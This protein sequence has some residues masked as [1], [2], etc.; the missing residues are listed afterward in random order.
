[1]Q[2]KRCI[3]ARTRI[4][5][6]RCSEERYVRVRHAVVV[7]C[8]AAALVPSRCIDV[9][10]SNPYVCS[11]RQRAKDTRTA[12]SSSDGANNAFLSSDSDGVFPS[13]SIYPSLRAYTYTYLRMHMHTYT[14][15]YTGAYIFVE[16]QIH[17]HTFASLVIQTY[18]YVHVHPGVTSLS[19]KYRDVGEGA[20]G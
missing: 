7:C 6:H 16:I 19:R 13:L 8:S 2:S 18:T 4:H 9:S 12:E 10:A 1:M 15:I 17:T 5:L 14:Y 20:R 11:E 3:Y